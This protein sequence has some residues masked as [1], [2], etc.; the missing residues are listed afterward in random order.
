VKVVDGGVDS[1]KALRRARRFEAPLL[2][3]ASSYRQMGILRPVVR[4][5][6]A[7]MLGGEPDRSERC[8][9]GP[10]AVGVDAS[11]GKAVFLEQFHHQLSGDP[12]VS[13]TLDLEVE[14]LAFIVDGPPEPI[15]ITAD[16]DHHFVEVPWS[17]GRG[18]ERRK[19]AAMASPNL[20]NHRR[21]V[22]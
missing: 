6:A 2:S 18:R 13:S 9:I 3:L 16:R 19:F 14:H 10:Q 20:K 8:R 15:T 12:G 1:E 17:L 5:Q 4:A 7:I 22:S 11:R 21:T